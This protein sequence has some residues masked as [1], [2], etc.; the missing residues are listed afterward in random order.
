MRNSLLIA[1]VF[2]KASSLFAKT[3]SSSYYFVYFKDKDNILQTLDKPWEY[4][5]VKAIDRRQKFGIG[6]DQSDLPVNPNYIGSI[7]IHKNIKVINR[8]KWM[9]G[10]EIKVDHDYYLEEIRNLPF[11]DKIQFLGRIKN[12]APSAIKPIDDKYYQKADSLGLLK[13]HYRNI[14]FSE[15]DYKRSFEQ[16]QIIG[17][18]YL[19]NYGFRGQKMLIA[20]FDAGF[21]EAYKVPG[22]E[23]LLKDDVL[24]LDLVDYDG[25]V[26]EDD[27]HGA[28]VL[29]FMKTFNPGNYIGTAPFADYALFRTEI[30][31]QEYPVEEINWIFAAEYA[32]SMGVDLISAS[33]GYHAFDDPKL[34]HP[35]H[36]LD[37]KTSLIAKAA[38]IAHSKGIAI[39]CSSGNE[40]NGT[41]RK[42]STP[43]DASSVITIGACDMK[44]FYAPFSSIGYTADG[45]IKPDFSVPGYKVMVASPGGFYAG[46]G[47]SYST[48]LFAGAFA[49]LMSTRLYASPD[50]IRQFVRQASSH[51]NFADSF[52]GYGIPDLGLA[53]CMATGRGETDSTDEIWVKTPGIY[54]Q[55]LNIYFKSKKDQK[56]RIIIKTDKGKKLKNTLTKTYRVEAGKWF[57][58]DLAFQLVNGTIKKRKKKRQIKKLLIIIE[59][60]NGTYQRQ[61]DLG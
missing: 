34:S 4:L 57:H 61:F 5:S 52:Y 38:N 54:H 28:K 42:I 46:N 41:W 27:S 43:G 21:Y 55:D 9:N 39:V 13:A 35:F 24:K 60:D 14:G 30:G 19:H 44:G 29:G 22:M 32:D 36:E 1:F 40:G 59:T 6:F 49:C 7:S 20:V 11:I 10:I 53:Y 17:I 25:S 31:N 16:N 8:S 50:S 37:G 45:R 48:P 23:D 56:I 15:K 33:V 26:W 51:Y 47:T 58:S 3:D 2:I 12:Q 18:P